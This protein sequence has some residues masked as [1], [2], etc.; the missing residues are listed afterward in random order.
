MPHPFRASAAHHKFIYRDLLFRK[1]EINAAM[2]RRF[3]APQGS[4]LIPDI[5]I[6]FLI[7]NR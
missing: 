5:K 4:I 1:D 7:S 3:A 2:R 6:S